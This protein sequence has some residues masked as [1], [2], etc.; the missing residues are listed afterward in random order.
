MEKGR[1]E[2]RRGFAWTG[3]RRPQEDPFD[4]GFQTTNFYPD[5]SSAL[6]TPLWLGQFAEGQTLEGSR[7]RKG[8][9]HLSSRQAPLARRVWR[10]QPGLAP[11][12]APRG[13][14]GGEILR[15]GVPSRRWI[16][17]RAQTQC[18]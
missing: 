5:F 8:A 12:G 1:E 15:S 18:H 13:L 2:G 10:L 14:T 16:W 11:G 17:G 3:R 9:G 4:P 7:K 6:T